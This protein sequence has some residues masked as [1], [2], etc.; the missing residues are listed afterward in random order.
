MLT[1]K[2]R[3]AEKK[4]EQEY[5]AL[6][7]KKVLV[8]EVAGYT[9]RNSMYDFE[10]VVFD[11]PLLVLIEDTDACDI[12]ER[13]RDEWLD[14]IFNITPLEERKE[15]AGMTSLVVSGTSRSRE[16]GV[17]QGAIVSVVE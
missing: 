1:Q 15:I 13:W 16:G 11:E 2:M 17:E 7:G 10:Y 6:V 8:K 4:A 12:S 9:N 3:E 5:D 14:P